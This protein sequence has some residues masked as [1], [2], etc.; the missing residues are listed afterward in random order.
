MHQTRDPI[1][2]RMERTKIVQPLIDELKDPG[3]R[4]PGPFAKPCPNCGHI[5]EPMY[6]Q[7]HI[8]QC[9]GV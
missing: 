7:A 9:N 8:A 3:P 6:L 5:I 4:P 1:T 2:G